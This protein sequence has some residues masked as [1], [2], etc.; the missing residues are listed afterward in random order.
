MTSVPPVDPS[1][2][3]PD[4][5]ELG[6]DPFYGVLARR[7]DV[8]RAW[9]ELDKVF[10]G[11]TSLV[12]NQIKEEARRTLAQGV[13][14]RFC[15][16]LGDPSAGHPS[17]REALAVAFA[18]QVASDHHEIDASMFD[19]LRE[20]FSDEEIVELVSWICFK[21]GSN[22]FGALMRLAPATEE[23]V[24]GYADFVAVGA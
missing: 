21:Y 15:A 7:P 19:V 24:R 13:G 16:S 20:E 2:L 10:F 17:P 3:P 5:E 8:L 1:N 23:Q 9:N 18:E 14:C 6:H 22:M 4:L 11:S 12:S